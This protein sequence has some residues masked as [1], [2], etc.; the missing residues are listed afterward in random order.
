ML[1]YISMSFMNHTHTICIIFRFDLPAK[2]RMAYWGNRGRCKACS[3]ED[4]AI[5]YYPPNKL[6]GRNKDIA[7]NVITTNYN[8]VLNPISIG[9][10]LQYAAC[11]GPNER[12]NMR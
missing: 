9:N 5:S 12:Q 6:S 11:P 1:A 2:Y 8:G 10:V 3:K 4:R 7:G